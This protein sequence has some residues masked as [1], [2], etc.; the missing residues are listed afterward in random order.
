MQSENYSNKNQWIQ[1]ST[2][3][4]PTLNDLCNFVYTLSLSFSP[5]HKPDKAKRH[6]RNEVVLFDK[7]SI[8]IVLSLSECFFLQHLA[9]ASYYLCHRVCKSVS[10]PIF[11]LSSE[12]LWV[13]FRSIGFIR[14]QT[15]RNATTSMIAEANIDIT[16]S[17]FVRSRQR[18]TT[19]LL[20]HSSS[21]WS[22]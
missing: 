13:V 3:I 12:H 10:G 14:S 17:I 8:I 9:V 5:A 15:R 6:P 4:S 21:M 16:R 22:Q 2:I 7:E 19:Y 11:G 18:S 20:K 1:K